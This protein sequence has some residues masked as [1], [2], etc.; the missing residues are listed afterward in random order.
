MAMFMTNGEEFV[1]FPHVKF[2]VYSAPR[3]RGLHSIVCYF[4]FGFSSATKSR[5][6]ATEFVAQSISQRV[7]YLYIF[8][9]I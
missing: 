4:P 8:P 2:S 6:V 7:M 5:G 3:E 9:R 1:I